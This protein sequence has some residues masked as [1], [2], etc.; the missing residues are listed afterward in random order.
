MCRQCQKNKI[1]KFY[2]FG[3]L[4]EYKRHELINHRFNHRQSHKPIDQHRLVYYPL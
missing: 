2:V 3:Y 1:T 4:L